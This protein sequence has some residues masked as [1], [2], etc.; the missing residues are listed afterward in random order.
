M[1]S[2]IFSK[3]PWI[4]PLH[5]IPGASVLPADGKISAFSGG[6]LKSFS[7]S[8]GP[9]INTYPLIQP[10]HQHTDNTKMKIGGE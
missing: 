10:I 1:F 4:F 5:A 7:A 8:Y 6:Y 2:S 9:H 3:F